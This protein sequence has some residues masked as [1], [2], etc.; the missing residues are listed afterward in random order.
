MF[1]TVM[2]AYIHVFS[3]VCKANRTIEDQ[4]RSM[5]HSTGFFF[6]PQSPNLSLDINFALTF[7]RQ[8]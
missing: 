4:V 3:L 6:F 5:Q 8:S 7:I 2:Y 1:H